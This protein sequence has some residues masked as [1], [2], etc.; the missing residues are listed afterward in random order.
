LCAGVLVQIDKTMGK[1]QSK[2]K[3]EVMNDLI[4]QTQFSRGELKLWYKGFIEDCT[5]GKMDIDQFRTVY[6]DFFPDGDATKFSEHVFRT[7]DTSG[8]GRI[9]FREF[10]TGLSI[11]SRGTT[12]ERLNWAFSLYDSDS[13]GMI[14][15]DEMLKV[16]SCIYKMV[17]D[18]HSW[19]A[20]ISTP[21][22]RVD[23]IFKEMDTNNDGVLALEEFIEG[24]TDDPSILTLLQCC[25][26]YHCLGS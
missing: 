19:P 26:T 9:D 3:P 11:T 20:D 16:I 8:D 15:R 6:T 13:N 24:A 12:K 4:Q 5:D 1:E 10:M 25:D 14:T 21:E 23:N 22:K 2:L 7:F 17:G 18:A